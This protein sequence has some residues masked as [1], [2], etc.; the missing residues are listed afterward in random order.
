MRGRLSIL[1][2]FALYGGCTPETAPE[3]GTCSLD[4]APQVLLLRTIHFA[5]ADANGISPGFD[6][7]G[8]TTVPGD[9]TGCNIADYTGPNGESGIDNAFTLLQP[10]LDSTE[11]KITAIEGLVQDAIDSG[12]LLIAIEVGGIDDWEAD[13]CVAGAVGKAEGT[14]MIGTDGLILDGQTFD[15]DAAVDPTALTGG[16]I[17]DGV[18]EARGLSFELPVQI[19]NANLVFPLREGGL[20]LERSGDDAFTGYLAGRVSAAYLLSVAQTENV[21]PAVAELLGAVL[22]YNADLTDDDGTECGAISVTLSFEAVGAY[23][24]EN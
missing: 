14:P 13:S 4:N 15:R 5:L 19:L 7:D 20:H 11:A 23:Y 8:T 18:L 2:A 22:S 9:G 3:D 12:A 16:A 21:D 17:T 10:A 6:L 24:Y 1:A